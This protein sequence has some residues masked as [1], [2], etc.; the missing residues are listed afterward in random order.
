MAETNITQQ[1]TVLWDMV[2][3]SSV[4]GINVSAKHGA[5]STLRLHLTK[6][7]QVGPVSM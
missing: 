6:L 5:A 7:M 1:I 3:C 2:L 4:T